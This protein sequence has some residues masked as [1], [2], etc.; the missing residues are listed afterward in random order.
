[1]SFLYMEQNHV[2]KGAM[3][4]VIIIEMLGYDRLSYVQLLTGRLVRQD[5]CCVNTERKMAAHGVINALYLTGNL[6][7]SDGM[8]VRVNVM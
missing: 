6:W 5:M 2:S 1:M 4:V 3:L 8:A 7:M